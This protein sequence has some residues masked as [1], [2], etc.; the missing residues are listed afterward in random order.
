MSNSYFCVG[1][2]F[3]DI[4]KENIWHVF[5]KFGMSNSWGNSLLGIAFSDNSYVTDSVIATLSSFFILGIL[6]EKY[7]TYVHKIWDGIAFGDNTFIAN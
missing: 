1:L 4:L 5:T 3:S 7:L 2:L 6:K